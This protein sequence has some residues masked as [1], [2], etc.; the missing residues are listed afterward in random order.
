MIFRCADHGEM[1]L[2][3]GGL[4]QKAFNAYE[5]TINVPLVVSS[6]AMFAEPRTTA[7]LASLVDVLPTM[8]GLAGV[9][10]PAGLRGHDLR[11][12]LDDPAASVRDSVVF[13]FDDHQAGTAMQEAPGQPNRLRAI[14]TATHKYVRYHDPSGEAAP[15]YELYDLERDP[16]ETDNRI[17]VR[18]GYMRS[19]AERPLRD[20]LDGLLDA[21][22][23]DDRRR[24]T[25]GSDRTALMGFLSPRRRRSTSR[26]G[27]RSRTCSGSSRS[28]RTGPSTAS[29]RPR[30]STC[31][32]SSS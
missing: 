20:E 22:L 12:V 19:T 25:G 1:G 32:T 23:A 8:L 11:P 26:S 17:D 2:S 21:A 16:L 4:R 5:E 24:A 6:P 30:P 14:R 7:A 27:R 3:H 10:P 15:E 31:S 13:T 28:P 29:A 9:E 18:S